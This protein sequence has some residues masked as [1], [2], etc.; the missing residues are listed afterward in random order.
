MREKLLKSFECAKDDIDRWYRKVC[1]SKAECKMENAIEC[2]GCIGKALVLAQ[3]LEY[4][5]NSDVKTER[6]C[7]E[8]IKK[9]LKSD[10]LGIDIDEKFFYT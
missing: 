2:I 1:R 7:M 6:I 4:D 3:I 9:Y 10:V 5:F 8:Q